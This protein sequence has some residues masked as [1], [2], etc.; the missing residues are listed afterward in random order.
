MR[1]S[2]ATSSAYLTRA[3]SRSLSLLVY[4]V[5]TSQRSP[6]ISTAD[7][8]SF[9]APTKA[10]CRSTNSCSLVCDL[11][12]AGQTKAPAVGNEEPHILQEEVIP[13]VNVF[14]SLL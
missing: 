14:I 7:T 13:V 3:A 6:G 2:A 5:A 8:I 4:H 9:V 12:H 1:G 10:E 11:P